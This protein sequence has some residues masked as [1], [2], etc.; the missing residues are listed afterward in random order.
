M[1]R[2][3]QITRIKGGEVNI[4]A[5]AGQRQ[6]ITE[7]IDIDCKRE[8]HIHDGGTVIIDH[9]DP[10]PL[11][12]DLDPTRVNVRAGAPQVGYE[13]GAQLPEY[14]GELHEVPRQHQRAPALPAPQSAQRGLPA[15]QG[16][17][18]AP[19]QQAL[20]AP[21]EAPLPLPAPQM[22]TRAP[23]LTRAPAQAALPAPSDQPMP[24]DQKPRD[25]GWASIL[26]PGREKR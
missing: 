1:T 7:R 2:R 10:T 23:A 20:P 5:P 3:P 8:I 24:A 9:R 26:F 19:A 21:R 16:R 22:R 12:I 13:H 6:T 25:R 15:P 17:A 4:N 14:R 18:P 11:E